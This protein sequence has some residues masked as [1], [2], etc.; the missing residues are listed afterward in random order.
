MPTGMQ[1]SMGAG[2]GAFGGMPAGMP[3]PLMP[4]APP[5]GWPPPSGG[6]PG[7]ALG[8][9][10][11]MMATAPGGAPP[12]VATADSRSNQYVLGWTVAR[13]WFYKRVAFAS[14]GRAVCHIAYRPVLGVW[15]QEGWRIFFLCFGWAGLGCRTR[16]SRACCRIC[17]C[18]CVWVLDCSGIPLLSF[19][20]C[21]WHSWQRREHHCEWWRGRWRWERRHWGRQWQRL[22]PAF[23]LPQRWSQRRPQ[24]PVGRRWGA[25]TAQAEPAAAE[26]AAGG[27]RRWR[28]RWWRG[29]WRRRRP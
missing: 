25:A 18:C 15:M 17:L 3:P 29:G 19:P 2:A 4:G 1:G 6:A 23:P 22:P 7:S 27:R 16:S 28:G 26:L 8:M 14:E 13:L 5:V 10:P 9:P 20:Q 11:A 21:Q 12:V 24:R